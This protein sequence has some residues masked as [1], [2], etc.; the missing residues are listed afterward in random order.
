VNRQLR[1]REPQQQGQALVLGLV[2]LFAGVLGLFFLFTTGQ[3]LASR[4]R[5]DNAADAAALSAATWRAR[6][7][8]F[9]AY[10]NRAILAQELAVAQAV[11][12]AS[13]ARYFDRFAT[14]VGVLAGAYP[15]A[16]SIASLASS[17]ATQ[18]RE[19]TEDAA[20]DEI[21]WRADPATGYKQLLLRSQALMHRSADSFGL[22]SVAN[23]VARANDP[24]FFAFAMSDAGAYE[25]MTRIHDT[26]DDRSRLARMVVD[27][28][29]PF[30][31]GP[32]GLD[33]PLPLL[34]SSCVAQ[35]TDPQR[36]IQWYR[37]R[38]GTELSD[39]LDRWQAAD[40]GSIHDWRRRRLLIGSCR[41]VES[42]PVG[43]GAAEASD[44]A[45]AEPAAVDEASGIEEGLLSFNPGGTQTNPA[46]TWFAQ[47]DRVDPAHPGF[48][49]Y[50]GIARVREL[51]LDTLTD[52]HFPVSRVAVLARLEARSVRTAEAIGVGTGRLRLVGDFPGGRIHSLASAE[53]YFRRP[54][55]A[56]AMIEFASLYN[57]WWQARL[58]EPTRAERAAAV[59]HAR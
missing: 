48:Q 19:L 9:N 14:G 59:S 27:S 41:D 53:V 43:W 20:S 16:A 26:V 54:P 52:P 46:A 58:V 36:W 56:P 6:V 18:A 3:V 7:F 47:A 10:S 2:L 11:T 42:V 24:R 55:G 13:W 35:S 8:N 1:I 30:T 21:A 28:L 57:P 50:D 39:G 5:L 37:K 45:P 23:E 22:G 15:P 33:L 31:S 51:D 44:G 12:L 34:P 4:Q 29:D 40:T 25:R 17:L 38:G 49:R 32:R